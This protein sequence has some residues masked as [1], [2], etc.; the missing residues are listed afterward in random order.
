MTVIDVPKKARLLI[1]DDEAGA[2][3][4]LEAILEDD[5][6]VVCVEDGHKALAVIQKEEFDLVLLDISM[7][8]ISG[9]KVLEQIKIYD[10][11]ID[12][13]IVS[14]IDR[15]L[16]ATAAIQKGAYDYITKPFDP[17]TILARVDRALQKRY[18]EQEV[19]F[20]RSEM[21]QHSK[22]TQ[23]VSQ[24]KQMQDVFLTINKVASTSS[25]V[26][27]TGESGT[28]KELI[29]RAIHNASERVQKPFV[30]LNCASIP[31][32]LIESEL[33]GHEKGAFTGANHR[34]PGKFE[35]ANGGTLLLDEISSLKSEFQAQLLRVLQ[36]REFTRVGGH[37]VIKVDVRI[38]AATNTK[39]E[40][41]AREGT[42]REDLFFRLN[43]IPINVPPL[44]HRGGDVP[45]LAHYFLAKFNRKLNKNIKVITPKA[46]AI[47]ET[48]PW[49]GNIRELENLIERMV[50]LGSDNTRIDQGDLPSD[51]LFHKETLHNLPGPEGN[52]IGL[53]QARHSFELNYIKQALRK[54][55]WNQT[56]AARLLKIHR[57]T[58]IQKMKALNIRHRD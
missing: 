27:I 52:N 57:N 11:S 40:D 33:F 7:P 26:L 13:I 8:K 5:Y 28:G 45:L 32:E 44:R 47:L 46:M 16:E 51:V 24:S 53:L 22:H 35:F 29:A 42:F 1:V 14:A 43:V 23:I 2:R 50:V 21:A 9:I 36:E 39:L 31:S 17:D 6:L 37:R 4:S 10:K 20:L 38:I 12:V 56:E 30:A 25:S 15:A 55:N 41:M 54:C 58:L 18:L 34:T 3:E 19:S 48:Y 49:P